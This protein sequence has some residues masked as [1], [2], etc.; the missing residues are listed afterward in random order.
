VPRQPTVD[1]EAGLTAVGGREEDYRAYWETTFEHTRRALAV[2]DP[3]TGILRA[4]NPAFAA[5]HGG[6]TEDFVGRPLASVCTA[7]GAAQIPALAREA[8]EKGFVEYQ[9]EN[10]RLDGSVFPVA[11]E[12]M[13]ARNQAG[14]LLYRVGWFED[15]T[16]AH[17]AAEDERRSRERFE[18]AFTDAPI[19]MALIA[20]EGRFMY[21]NAALRDMTGYRE[22]ALTQKTI[23]DL[24]HPDDMEAELAQVERLLRGEI[25]SFRMEMRYL[26][27]E[28]EVVWILLSA[29]IVR[30]ES[31]APDHFIA[32]MEDI[33][34]KKRSEEALRRAS[35]YFEL[36]QDLVC[37]AGFDGVFR[38]VGEAWTRVLGWSRE[39]LCS[40]PFVEFVH[41]DDRAATEKEA[42]KLA[43]DGATV[44]FT[45]RYRTKDGGWCWL[46]WSCRA[47]MDEERIYGA[48]RVVNERKLMEEELRAAHGALVGAS[49][50]RRVI[51]DSVAE[52]IL[53]ADA[54]GR[55]TFANRAALEL[56]GWSA[57]ELVGRMQHDVLHHTRA[58]GTPYPQ[59]ECPMYALL[60]TGTGVRRDDEVFWRRDGT[61]FPVEYVSAPLRKEGRIVGAVVAFNNVTERKRAEAEVADARDRAL[62]ASRAKSSFLA[63]MS[64]EIRTPMNGVVGMTELLLDT[65][66]DEEQREYARVVSTSADALLRV[67]D[68]ILDFSKIEAG[69]LELD[70]GYFDPR[71][72]VGD[73]CTMLA[74]AAHE[75]ELALVWSAREGVP[76]ALWG[77]QGRFRQV[78]TNLIANAI[79]FTSAGEVA[80]DVSWSRSVDR[81]ELLRVEVSDTGIGIDS[82]RVEELFESFQQADVSTTRKYGGT[83][84][85]LAI[86]KQ[87]VE[88]MGGEIGATSAP[89]RGSTFWFTVGGETA[90]P[91]TADDHSRAEADQRSSNRHHAA[92]DRRGAA[93]DREEAA[94]DRDRSHAEADQRTWDRGRAAADREGAA[95]DREEA[96]A[97]RDQSLAEADRRTSDRDHAAAD[98]EDAAAVREEAAAARDRTQG[99]ADQ[100]TFDRD[101]A[102]AGREGAAAIREAAA[103]ARDRTQA[104]ADERT[105][106]RDDAAAGREGAAVDRE[107]AA[108]ARDQTQAE[109]D[110]RTSDR[111]APP[112][113][114]PHPKP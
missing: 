21:V 42:A 40:R 105:S 12:V 7:D 5:L 76:R 43:E 10:V 8:D 82:A 81:D 97:A 55:V 79:K 14:E 23:R 6:R 110:E 35:R 26:C 100:R 103:A 114:P 41:P 58:D 54:D 108:A 32:Q 25:Q 44:M 27:A 88:L 89:G 98:R 65:G 94:A 67:I 18:K 53:S 68:D 71:E 29:S 36:S 11:I 109:T 61:S 101:H 50:E 111:D 106:N 47:V 90:A 93:V 56:T 86:S 19:G 45:N 57:E 28:D 48:A 96:A 112:W 102:A 69:K 4:V 80:V 60:R 99:E 2:A 85:G 20:L 31:G 33:S 38:E 59:A 9:T 74:E 39:E 83:G 72:S 78:V 22:E 92:A 52:G 63:N 51:L 91:S 16:A 84:L 77:D 1:L 73:V 13:A 66:L 113:E 3:G 30:D 70:P 37:L 46:E 49:E 15:L 107:E 34:E 87:L 75:K 64:H 24:T 17:R 62:D 104:E 95:V